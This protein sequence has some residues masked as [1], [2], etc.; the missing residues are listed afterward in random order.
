MSTTIDE[1]VVEMRFDNRQFESATHES[2]STLEKLKRS[3]NLTGASKGLEEV[4]SAAKKVDMR[5]LNNAVETVQSRFSALEIMGV[6]AL[7]N[8]TNQ[9]VN[10]GKRIASALT[11][12]P[13]KTGFQEYETQINAVQ[14]ILANTES[15]GTTIDDV[16]RALDELNEYA[17]LTIY[18]FTEMTRNIGKFTAAGVDLDT[19]V[20]AIKGIANLAAVSGSTSQQASTAMYQLSQALASGTVK[21]MDWNSVVNAGMGGEVFQNALKRTATVM[22]TNVDA[23]IEKYGSFRDSLSRGGWLTADV[24]NETLSQFTMAAEEGTEQWEEYK[25]S[26]QEKGYTEE[27]VK[28]ILKMANTATD[29]AT[30]V[31]TFTQLWDVLKESAQS[32]WAQTWELLIGDFEEAKALITPL[33]DM[34]S[35]FITKM[36]KARNDLLAGALESPLGKLV[37]KINKVTGATETMVAVTKDYGE[38]VDKVI[39]GAYGNG[40]SRW[41]K[42]AE[43]GYD[44]AKVQNLVNEKLGDSTRH[45]EQLVEAQG[46]QQKSQATTIEQL[47]KM[48]DVQ[49][50]NLGFEKEEIKALRELAEQSK[51]TGIPIKDLVEDMD[52]LS[53]RELLINSFKNAGSGLV[54]IFKAMG[55]AWRSIFD[56]ITSEQLYDIIAALHNFS[57]NL[58]LTDKETG[59]LTDTGKKLLRTFKGIFAIVSIVTDIIGGGLKLAF[60]AVTAILGYFHL[61]ILDVTAAIGDVLV[62]FREATDVTKL[63]AKAIDKIAP[64][65]K[66]MIDAFLGLPIVQKAIERIKNTFNELKNIDLRETGSYI[67]E[68]LKNG[69][70]DGAKGVIDVII[71]L[72]VDLIN[73][74]KEILGIHSPSRE[75][76]ENGKNIILGLVNGLTDFGKLVW[77]TITNIGST[78]VDYFK[79]INFGQIFALAVSAGMVYFVKKVGDALGMMS[80]PLEGIAGILTGTAKVIN[81]FS[82][83]LG[84]VSSY[85]KSNALKNVAISIAILAGS[86]VLLALIPQEKLWSAVKAIMALAG[87]IVVLMA[88]VEGLAIL[89][90]KFGNGRTMDFGKLSAALLGV[91][92]SVLLMA[93]AM[94]KIG[95]IDATKMDQAVIG[96]LTIVTG[97]SVI[98]ATYGA[99]VKGKSAQNIAK[100]GTMVLLLSVSILLIAKAMKDISLLEPGD[101]V[102]GLLVVT[103]LGGFIVGLIAASKLAGRSIDKVGI[104]M[105]KIASAIGS[106][107]VIIKLIS[108]IG[109][110]EL[111][112]GFAVIMGFVSIITG[113]TWITT[114]AG[115]NVNKLGSTLAGMAASMLIMTIVIKLLGSMD[116]K[117]LAKG[118]VG[119]YALTGVIV[120]LVI[121]TNLVTL[122][123]ISKLGI[124]LIAIAFTIGI[125]GGISVLLGMVDPKM[126]WRGIGAVAVLSILLAGLIAVTFFAKDVKGDLIVLSVAIAVLAGSVAVL[127][128]IEPKKLWNATLAIGLLMGIFAGMITVTQFAGGSMASLIVMTVAV[129]VLAGVLFL[130]SKLPV[131]TTLP[132]AIALGVLM[133]AMAG[134]MALIG[135]F[136]TMATMGLVSLGVMLL[137]VG[138]LAGILYLIRDLPIQTTIVNAL[139]LS[140][141]LLAMSG[142]MAL[143]GSFGTLATGGLITLGVMTLVVGALAGIL[144]LIRDLPIE[145]TMNNVKALSIL[146]LAMSGACVILGVV[147]LM[148]PAG[149]I[150][151][152]VLATLIVAIGGL[153]A[154][155]GAL[156]EHIPSMEIMLDKGLPILEKIGYALGSF[157]GNIVAG[158]A[159]G[160]LSGLPA[161]GAYLSLF[162]ANVQPFIAGAKTIDE[163]AM[164]GVKV[165]AETLLIL[166]GANIIDSLSSWLTGGS[167]LV[168]FGKELAEFAPYFKQYS[169]TISGIDGTTIEAS[170]NAAKALVEVANAIPNEGGLLAKIT[171]DNSL[172]T[173]AKELV[174]FGEQMSAYAKTVKGFN[175]EDVIASTKA[176]EALTGL[177]D[178]V[179]NTGGLLAKIAG[180]NSLA[181]F[182]KEL[183]PFGE[184]IVKYAT[185]VKGLTSENVEASV[186]AGKMIVGLAETIPNSGG[187]LAK[188]TGDNSLS[189]FAEELLPFGVKIK[190]Y[191]N[192]VEGLK[193]DGIKTSVKAAKNIIEIA[194]AIPNSGNLLSK[195]TGENSLSEFANELIPFAVAI[196]GYSINAS[197]INKDAV[198]ASISAGKKIIS[199]INSL[200]SLN[201]SGVKSYKKALETL[202]GVNIDN[203]V[204]A[205]KTSTTDFTAT[206]RSMIDGIVMGVKTGETS[207]KNAAMNIVNVFRSK[208][209]TFNDVGS[210]LMTQFITGLNRQKDRVKTTATSIVTQAV[211]GIRGQYS[212]F[213][214]A[215]SYLGSGLVVGINSMMTAVYN[216]AYKLGQKAAQ[217]AKDGEDAHSPS[218]EGIKA[219]EWLGEGL[220]IGIANMGRKVYNAGHE[221]GEEAVRSLSKAMVGVNDLINSDMDTQPTI[222]PVLDLSDVKSGIGSINGMFN[223]RHTLGVLSN[224][225]TISSIVNGRQ[226][227]SNDDVVSAI[228]KL[229]GELGNV[230]NT[231]YNVNGITYDDGSNISNAV[232]SLVRAARMERR[233]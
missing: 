92:G 218:R 78:I 5:G 227:G 196:R 222:R 193:N 104:T 201:T 3:L 156:V 53:G 105:L 9:A 18:N 112:R 64:Y 118:I 159:D 30:K 119:I 228:N 150:G 31:K 58:R 184:Q 188:I 194:N 200:D 14:T 153:M 65:I 170:A 135:S 90:S 50:K 67:I 167:S 145:S 51:K 143:I 82:K 210:E 60:K 207:M 114:L 166:T 7:V 141:L 215:G 148:G 217:G 155:L 212:S 44:W 120:A 11:I 175:D 38:I 180:E 199:F 128:M 211:T 23:L 133:L 47:T 140:V 183:V 192:V 91:S 136:G 229:R 125:I 204:N 76:Y 163:S 27:Q 134:S 151:V 21:L 152:G 121:I 131:E 113:L 216:A 219:G 117:T 161:I 197:G 74:F 68:G 103:L 158:F 191:S 127:S 232:Q 29:A 130:I 221:M 185:A 146:L 57:T 116:G 19:S 224:V 203:F 43:E 59:E 71:Q 208:K 93:I 225:D 220:V 85:I 190:E 61:D 28:E 8:I 173:F 66:K 169:E 72:A 157:A 189:A 142:S 226:N 187:L 6:T 87:V 56:P 129:A 231:T 162:M 177:A 99:I 16:N 55:E 100:A 52:Q 45:T 25:K 171:G 86:V 123:D 42:L 164:N 179:P 94:K 106:M 4:N 147:G 186:E 138:A 233:V 139:A 214:S 174:P 77:E 1:R 115:P 36:S 40:Q 32:G 111:I 149:L 181:D 110:A 144:Y 124:T 39:G 132:N 178:A 17:D 81:K 95:D 205:F 26:L 79:N 63:F 13:V 206:G 198:N 15:K 35:G 168:D 62:K 75:F 98:L 41:D 195:I 154:G 34:A 20:S 33:A 54:G 48:T 209:Q 88:V 108:W 46:E 102:K 84:S 126:L 22:G 176:G 165:L 202:G 122:R 2:L 96:I 24:L 160:A 97:I 70:G 137:A 109:D 89:Y 12:A 10:A 69:L 223:T 80:G 213:V 73:K 230:G 37:E 107:V 49:L 182:A 101:L 83:V 172:A